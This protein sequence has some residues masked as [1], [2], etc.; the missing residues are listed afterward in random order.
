MS[1]SRATPTGAALAL[2]L[3]PHIAGAQDAPA[4]SADER[5]RLEA[6]LKAEMAQGGGEAAETGAAPTGPRSGG[7]LAQ[8]RLLDLSFDLLGAALT[9]MT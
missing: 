7:G 8:A 6:E 3:L 5:A 9:T 1:R 4:D 2:V